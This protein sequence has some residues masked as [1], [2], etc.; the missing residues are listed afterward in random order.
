MRSSPADGSEVDRRGWEGPLLRGQACRADNVCIGRIVEVGGVQSWLPPVPADAER[1]DEQAE[2]DVEAAR[3]QFSDRA[4][5]LV[6][7]NAAG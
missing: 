6:F 7:D 4:P 1:I 3:V 5:G 2:H